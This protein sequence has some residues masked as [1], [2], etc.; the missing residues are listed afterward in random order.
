M[1]GSRFVPNIGVP[2][3]VRLLL[4]ADSSYAF[5]ATTAPIPLPHSEKYFYAVSQGN[6]IILGNETTSQIAASLPDEKPIIQLLND[7]EAIFSI[8]S[9]GEVT[10]LDHTGKI[11]WEAKT[12]GLPNVHSI[13]TD[14]ALIVASDSAIGAFDVHS[15]EKLWVYHESL[16]VSSI[17]YDN[18]SDLIIAA[19]S[20]NNP[21]AGD[22]I[23]CIARD[24]SVKS[25]CGFASAFIISNL[26]LCG[27]DKDKIAFGYVG[28]TKNA[29]SARTM[30]VVIY[31]GIETGNPKNI[32][33]HEVPY[34]PMSIASNQSVVLSSGFRD[35]GG[36][37]E[38]GLD[39]FYAE[40][41]MKLWQRRLSYPIVLSPAISE[42]YAYFSLT[43]STQAAVPTQS[44]FYTIDISTGKT[45]GELP[46]TGAHNGFATGIPVPMEERG[47]ML[48]D[49]NCAVIYFLKP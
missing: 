22:S 10:S 12:R 2:S 48:K 11:I 35:S 47:F 42:K 14:H 34:L 44:I 5:L 38:S 16:S 33:D 23:I 19:L 15:G 21:D 17:I 7:R 40:D 31:S 41:T 8:Q 18:K 20:F 1:D 13:L 46:V 29:G 30:H 9:D 6:E 37:L 26:C 4:I 27:K 39:A 32:S 3:T 24:G 28:K 25:R 49:R 43:F 45:L 36:D